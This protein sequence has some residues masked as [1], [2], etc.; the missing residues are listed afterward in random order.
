MSLAVLLRAALPVGSDNVHALLCELVSSG[1]RSPLRVHI[2]QAVNVSKASDVKRGEVVRSQRWGFNKLDH[3][4]LIFDVA[5]FTDERP[6]W[7]RGGV[8]IE[9]ETPGVL[10]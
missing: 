8:L 10:R 1:H 6:L 2:L 7:I 3:G 4:E 9:S 5:C